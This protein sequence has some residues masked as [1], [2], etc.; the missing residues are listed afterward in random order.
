M[1]TGLIWPGPPG[2][3]LFDRNCSHDKVVS[4][5]QGSGA[6]PTLVV[7]EG[8]VPFTSG[9]TP[10]A[11]RLCVPQRPCPPS[12]KP[13]ACLSGGAVGSSGITSGTPPSSPSVPIPSCRQQMCPPKHGAVQPPPSSG[14][15]LASA[16][17]EAA[18]GLGLWNQLR[19]SCLWPCR[20]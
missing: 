1:W 12:P 11:T 2:P 10:T 15:P 18:P 19:L 3:P 17:R 16:A 9:E 13:T 8:L 14:G 7:E 5:L 20:L 4:M 6:M